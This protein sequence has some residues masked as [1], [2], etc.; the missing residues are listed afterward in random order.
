MDNI[1]YTPKKL[2]SNTQSNTQSKIQSNIQSNKQILNL[3]KDFDINNKNLFPNLISSS[4]VKSDN[5]QPIINWN[6]ITKNIT[7]EPIKE[8]G[9]KNNNNN[10][11]TEKNI[12]TLEPINDSKIDK[13]KLTYVD[14]SGWTH[15]VKS[16]KP[17]YKE[18]KKKNI[19]DIDKLIETTYKN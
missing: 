6:N 1:N 10:K 14:E 17:A 18:K 7:D 11:E 15:I 3:E 4:V 13:I 8:L 9:K 16:K 12:T 2:Q 5:S 19:E